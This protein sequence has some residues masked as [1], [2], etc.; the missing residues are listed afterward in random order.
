MVEKDEAT[1]HQSMERDRT[2]FDELEGNSFEIGSLLSYQEGAIVSRTLLNRETVT[3]TLFAVDE[4]QTIS[5]H[6]APHDALLQVLDGTA[7]V[8]IG[9][10]THEVE[11][12]E[13]LVIPADEPHAVDAPTRFKMFLTMAR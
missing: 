9:D 6:T 12:G 11:A 1:E 4:E 13:A 7:S 2:Q 10:E 5:E 3:L 8:R